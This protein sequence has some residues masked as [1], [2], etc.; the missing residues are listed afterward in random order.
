MWGGR[1]YVPLKIT[2]DYSLLKSTIKIEEL[3]SFLKSHHLTAGALVDEN[4]Y[5]VMDFY[6]HCKQNEITPIIGLELQFNGKTF[7][8]Y[9]KNYDGYQNLLKIH[10]IKETRSVEVSDYELY[11]H[12]LRIILPF[13]NSH[14]YHEMAN[15]FE[16]LWIGYQSYYERN[17]AL[18]YTDKIVY[19]NDI[20]ALKREDTQSLDYLTMIQN[21]ETKSNFTPRNYEKNYFIEKIEEEDAK[22]TFLFSKDLN[23][24]I[25][26]NNRYIPHFD[27]TIE[28]S[29]DY[30]KA[31]TKKG[32]QK[33]CQNNV[34]KEYIERLK[35]ELAVI[36]KMGFVDYFLIVYDYV[37]FAKKNNILVG[38]GRGS[39]AGSLVS[40]SLGITD[41]DP[42]KYHLLFERF[43]NPDRITMPDI[44]IDF[45]YTKRG[46]VIEYVKQKYHEDCV[47]GIMTFGTLGSK[48]V[49]RDIGKCLELDQ[50]LVNKFVAYIDPKKTLEE[51]KTNSR[52]AFYL[53]NN[54]TIQNWYQLSMKVEGLKRHIS[55]HAAGVVI[56]SHPLDSVIPICYSGGEMLTGVTMNYLEELGLL[57][58]D[59]LALR[60]LTIIQNIL[61]LI[62]MGTQEEI[63]LN[64]I[65]LE[66]KK[67]L[68]LFYNADTLGIF[69]F[70][71][72][73]MTHFMEKLR[74]TT[75]EDL[76]AALALFRPGPMENIDSF[77][78]RKEGKEKI[79]YLHKDLEEILKETYGIIVYQEQIMQILSKIG[80]FTF[81]ESDNIRRA[82]SKK[83]KEVIEQSHEKFIKGAI[84][85]GYE[86]NLA[87]KIYELILKF[88]NYGFNKAHS[89]SYALIGYRM[90]YLKVNYP[91]YYI[92][93]LLNMSID[94]IEKTKEYIKEAKKRNYQIIHPD[95]N[96]SA[97]TYQIVKNTLIL[98]FTIIKNLGTESSEAIIKEREKNGKYKDFF[99]FVA[100]TYK[101]S[102]NKKTI[103]C[104]IDASAFDEM[105]KS[106]Q[107]LKE[108]ID[109]AINYA[110]LVGDSDQ[111]RMEN[112]DE[113]GV[114][115]PKLKR[116]EEE[117]IDTRGKELEIF[118]F[119]LSNHP[120]SKFQSAEITKCENLP[121]MFDKYVKC[122]VIIE[123]IRR[124]ETKQKEPMAFLLASDETKTCDFVAFKQVY[125]LL[126]DLKKNDLVLIEGKVT[127]RFDKY[128]VNVT[129]I[130]KQ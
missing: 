104:L 81:Q 103:E 36:E 88:S 99:D 68:N 82:M 126:N 51:N 129:N 71:S 1:M 33:R 53:E 96:A 107:T 24:E 127:K 75:F 70:E 46:K 74:P 62:R 45:E 90:A 69:Q 76:V 59:F 10:T 106:H 89:V 94:S 43:L 60:N 64:K 85:K 49:L 125:P 123:N 73:G 83:K 9:A 124:I 67:V 54:Q 11:H 80:G 116:V 130:I 95:I 87:E 34:P 38:P 16:D 92:A 12:H 128:Q 39:A 105:E 26:K 44:D 4:L 118:G 121:K 86:Q 114:M 47:A 32:L 35:Y 101:K 77:I 23:V 58:M 79:D 63:D 91:I 15:V 115:K 119:Y 41:V 6:D 31:L 93:N 21:G 61:D 112:M 108:N 27:D 50:E 25:P 19:V 97:S 5:G 29:L 20:R 3:I 52:V 122:I 48:L 111:T 72:S 102:I 100:R 109:A 66:D 13:E 98:P 117:E 22:T 57:K 14:L 113:Y 2:S 55:T 65:S 110:L 30:L 78:R 84:A 8:A 37:R 56:S 7:Y 40:Y 120:A 28:N 17:S 42:I 18:I